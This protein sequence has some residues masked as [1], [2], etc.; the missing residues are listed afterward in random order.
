MAFR[1]STTLASRHGVFHEARP[2]CQ[3]PSGA[4]LPGIVHDALAPHRPL[5]AVRRYAF[6]LV[7]AAVAVYEVANPDV[8]ERRLQ[9]LLQREAEAEERKRATRA[10]ATAQA[11]E[12]SRASREEFRTFFEAAALA[13]KEKAAVSAQANEV[14]Q[15]SSRRA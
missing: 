9:R 6:A 12:A 10:A 14:V 7:G 13:K 3:A 11:N 2:T 4:S 15:V 8:G 1:G 5:A